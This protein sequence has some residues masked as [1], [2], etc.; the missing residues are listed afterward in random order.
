M[1]GFLR[2]FWGERSGFLLLGVGLAGLIVALAA[3]QRQES[4]ASP[5]KLGGGPRGGTFEVIAAALAEVLNAGLPSGQITVEKSGGSIDNLTRVESGRLDMGL[6]FAGDAFLGARG[7]LKTGLPPT[8]NVQALSRLYGATAQLIVLHSSV[9]Q[10]VSNLRGRRIA[11][12]GAGAGSALAARRYFK[13]LGM[14][15]DIIP[16]H[17]G[18]QI[19]VDDLRAGNLDAVWLQ[20]GVPSEYLLGVAREVHLRFL[21]LD[22]PAQ[23]SALFAT[24]P[25]YNP[26]T[27]PS[28]TY[29]GQTQ[30]IHSFQDAAL[31]VANSGVSEAATYQALQALFSEASLQ[32][33]HRQYP[34]V[35]DLT[36]NQGLNGVSIPLHPGAK[37]FW[38]DQDQSP[39][40]P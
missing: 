16:I 14:W 12:G 5:L 39:K 38:K 10:T 18:Y 30:T 8:K 21:D 35:R 17:V 25:F 2:R 27:I 26:V 36:I 37:Q 11:I 32:R 1:A 20:V 40:A 6:V 29:F 24:Y 22:Q 15:N 19:A 23:S 3:C 7:E 13:C 33:L 31:W 9:I 4:P 34:E 28:G